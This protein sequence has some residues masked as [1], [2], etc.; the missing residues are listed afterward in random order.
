MGA[1]LTGK[2]ID[3]QQTRRLVDRAASVIPLFMEWDYIQS[4]LATCHQPQARMTSGFTLRRLQIPVGPSF[5][6]IS[7]R[8]E[9]NLSLGLGSENEMIVVIV[10]GVVDVADV[11][12]FVDIVDVDVVSLVF[13]DGEFPP[14]LPPC[15]VFP[16]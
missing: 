2:Y 10:V 14:P 7:S 16:E 11:V 13:A 12:A 6:S 3:L 5:H 1:R 8:S 4:L 9:M 15:D